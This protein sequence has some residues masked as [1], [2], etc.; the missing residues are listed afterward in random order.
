MAS[1]LLRSNL[2]KHQFL[3]FELLDYWKR[4]ISDGISSLG[5]LNYTIKSV[6]Y[7][8]LFT[9]VTID[10]GPAVTEVIDKHRVASSKF[11]FF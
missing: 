5:T 8:Y 7:D 4:Y 1:F 3:R 10:I 6:K 11:S 9:N 2:T